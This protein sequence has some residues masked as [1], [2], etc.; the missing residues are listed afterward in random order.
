[1]H[2]WHAT[3]PA[4][5]DPARTVPTPNTAAVGAEPGVAEELVGVLAC[6]ALAAIGR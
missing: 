6:M 1:L 2:A 3:A 4:P 5:P